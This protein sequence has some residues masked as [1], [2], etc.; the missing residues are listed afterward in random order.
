MGKKTVIKI[1]K[2]NRKRLIISAII[3]SCILFALIVRVGYLQFVKSSWLKSQAS[4]NQTSSKTIYAERGTIFDTNGA[5]LAISAVFDSVSINPSLIQYTNKT[6]VNKEFLAHSFSSILDLDYDET[7]AKINENTTY[8]TLASKVETDKITALKNWMSENKI[9]AGIKIE[10]KTQRNYPYNNIASNLIGFTGT[11]NTGLWGLEN[12]LNS[13]LAGTNG[14]LVTLVDSVKGE[15]PNQERT[16]IEAKNGNN[17]YLT[18]DIKIQSITEKYLAQ[19]VDDNNADSGVAIIMQPSSGDILAMASYPNYNLNDPFTPTNSKLLDNWENLT[20]EE[21]TNRRYSMWNNIA[22]QSTYEPGS[23]FKIITAAAALEE[24]LITTDHV[25]DFVCNGYEIIDGEVKIRCWRANPHGE[26][27]LRNALANS[28]NP[29]FMQLGQK[30][31]AKTLYEYYEAFGLFNKTN[32]DFY[33]EQNSIFFNLNDV[34][35]VELATIS[36]GQR[37]NITPMQLVTAVSC[38]ANEGILVEP[39]IVKRIQNPDTNSTIEI[40]KKEIRQVISKKTSESLI[41]MLESVVTDGTGKY[42]KVSGYTVGGKS[43][44]SEPSASSKDSGYVASFIAVAPST[45]PEVVILVALFNPKAGANEGGAIS[46]PVVSQILSEV[47]PHMG[48]APDNVNTSNS[49]DSYTTTTLPDLTNKSLQDAKTLLKNLGFTVHLNGVEDLSALVT[50]QNPK[51]GVLLLKNA[52]V[53]LYSNT[54]R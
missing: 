11:D 9:Y 8:V 27:S 39:H 15:I 33:G 36:F 20:S 18:I 45:N 29:A 1:E 48:I 24:G 43:G 30:I 16:Y 12:S 10:S 46:A 31:G 19:A 4:S 35:N 2:R 54:S 44:T 6:E 28:C 32:S 3:S 25:G 50:S 7:L 53:Y 41:S 5:V 34:H 23:T 21:K 17:I 37:F 51:P 26:Q 22:V 13:T 52:D 38:I 14:K 40:E 49:N 42:A 47:L